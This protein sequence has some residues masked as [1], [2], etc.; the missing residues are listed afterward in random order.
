VLAALDALRELDLLRRGQERD[1]ADV[2]EEELE[3]VGR[4]LRL[5]MGLGLGL[6]RLVGADDGD[7]RLV[8]RRV[9]VVELCR[10]EIE[11][12]ER[13]RELVGIDAA[14][15]VPDLQEPLPLVAREDFLDRRSSGS[16][17]R[18]VSGQTAPLPRERSHRSHT[19][20]GRQNDDPLGQVGP[21]RRGRH[22]R[23]GRLDRF[24]RGPRMRATREA[25]CRQR[26]SAYAGSSRCSRS[27]SSLREGSLMRRSR[28]QAE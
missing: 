4:D 22:V 7:L 2:L 19:G 23:F 11:L 26:R 9:D 17:L 1:L 18:V 5:G 20:G 12:V 16:A 25:P 28:T 15:A 14:R 6:V 3:R 21:G 24:D 13:E 27:P 8:E 10:L